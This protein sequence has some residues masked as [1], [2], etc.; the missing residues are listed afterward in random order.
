MS[1]RIEFASKLSLK[2]LPIWPWILTGFFSLLIFIVN[3]YCIRL[4][5]EKEVVPSQLVPLPPGEEEFE[6][7]QVF[8]VYGWAKD[9]KLEIKPEDIEIVRVID[10]GFFGSVHLAKLI[11]SDEH[12]V[13]KV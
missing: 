12:I 11:K 7:L 10:E 9:S 6:M 4:L 8:Y 1:A 5:Y 13:L 3:I 2:V